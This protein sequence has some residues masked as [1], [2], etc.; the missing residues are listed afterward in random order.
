M[1]KQ[2]R[3]KWT[4]AA[5]GLA[6]VMGSSCSGSKNEPNEKEGVETVLPSLPNEVTVVK[7]E[8]KSFTHDLVS[9][10]K[11][12]AQ[13]Y[14][15]LYF[16]S[17]EAVA[18][19]YVKNGDMVTKGQKL[20]ELDKYRLELAL[21]QAKDRL[22]QADLELKDVLI[23]QGYAPDNLQ[24]V[25]EE[26]LQLAK[27]KSGYEQILSA[28]E[29]AVK[30]LEQATLTAPFSG[31][32]AN[33]FGKIHNRASTA[34]AFCRIINNRS[35]EVTFNVL[36]SEL[37]LIR[38]GDKVVI[39]PYTTSVGVQEGSISEINPL[40]DANSMVYVKA[41]LNGGSTL[42]DGMNVRVKVQ[43][44]LEERLTVPKSAVVLRSNRQVVFTLKEGKAMWNYV[45]TGLENMDSF[46][47][48][49]GLTEGD[50][51]IVT[52]NLNLAHETPVN[53]VE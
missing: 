35:M 27:V 49:E 29:L 8:K 15:D 14:A 33:L 51:V 5:L 3:N 34:E 7:L 19:I 23:G 48:E 36:E 43:R 20:A 32:V 40:V 13:E 21:K 45:Q 31:V 42:F 37:P 18:R 44:T 17:V 16:K 9:N 11:I 22:Q 2:N 10:G 47:I 41:R 46:T 4:I 12:E 50:T 26:T 30:E 24:A 53:V 25:P 6:I 1:R 38:K 28:Y 39:T 52:G